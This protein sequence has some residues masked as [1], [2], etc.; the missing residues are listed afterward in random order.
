LKSG[1]SVFLSRHDRGATPTIRR[2]MA[3]RS[4]SGQF[5]PAH[6]DL[7]S[8]VIVFRVRDRGSLAR[9]SKLAGA[10]RMRPA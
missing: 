6:D 4:I 5:G 1:I 10:I 8:G 2:H 7:N 3:E 9:G